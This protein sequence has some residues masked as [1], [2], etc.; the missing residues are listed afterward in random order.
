M[1]C[2]DKK[3]ANVKTVLIYFPNV[4]HLAAELMK[5]KDSAGDVNVRTV[6]L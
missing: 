6:T 4:S 3:P 1:S 5:E 2:L